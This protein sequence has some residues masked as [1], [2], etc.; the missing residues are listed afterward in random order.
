MPVTP[1][2]SWRVKLSPV[3]NKIIFWALV[4]FTIASGALVVVLD[5]PGGTTARVWS[6]ATAAVLAL[7]GGG[8]Q[9]QVLAA[10]LNGRTVEPA[11]QSIARLWRARK[12]VEQITEG[13][14]PSVT[15]LNKAEAFGEFLNLVSLLAALLFIL[16]TLW[17]TGGV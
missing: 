15:S 16:V 5:A 2:Q 9:V 4:L 6:T 1:A 10:R 14:T 11:G 7:W 17:V 8:I 3:R 13:R 12:E